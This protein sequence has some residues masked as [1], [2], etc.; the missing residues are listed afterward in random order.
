MSNIYT[1]ENGMYCIDCS[2]ALWSTSE[3]HEAYHE[4]GLTLK[5]VDFVI[6]NE[7]MLILME[8]KNANIPNACR[9]ESFRPQDEDKILK[10]SRKYF[11]S[12]HYLNLLRKDKP[13]RFVYVVES[14]HGDAVLRHR[15]RSLLKDKLPFTLQ[16]NMSTGTTLIEGVDVLSIDEWNHDPTYGKYPIMPV[17]AT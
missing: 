1:E 2:A 10:V 8:Y 11:D 4:A 9:P 7:E 16:E 17:S 6:E 5:D 15:V 14:V 13:K 3:I 12:L